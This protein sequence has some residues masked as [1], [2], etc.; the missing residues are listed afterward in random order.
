M[1]CRAEEN[2]IFFASVNFAHAYQSAATALIGPDGRCLAQVPYGEV[3]VAVAE[4]DP[5]AAGR[6]YA[7]RFAPEKY[8][9]AET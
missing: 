3:G 2:E 6:L 4:I 1:V 5:A 7:Q 8:R 9:E